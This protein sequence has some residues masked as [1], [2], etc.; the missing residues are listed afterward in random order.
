MKSKGIALLLAIFLGGLGAHKFYLGRYVTGV[1]YLV[2]SWTFI[3]VAL[4]LIDFLT[5]LIL[6]DDSFAKKYNCG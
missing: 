1:L 2:F 3:P 6:T 5:L 4:S